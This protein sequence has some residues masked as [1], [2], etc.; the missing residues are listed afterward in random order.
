MW[1]PLGKA[2]ASTAFW[3]VSSSTSTRLKS[4][5][6][7]TTTTTDAAPQTPQD[8]F[9]A[10]RQLYVDLEQPGPRC[11]EPVPTLRFSYVTPPIDGMSTWRQSAAASSGVS[12]ANED[13]LTVATKDKPLAVYLPGLDGYGI[14]AA[15]NQFDDLASTFE[16]WRLT[17]APEDRSS[18]GTL[19]VSISDFVQELAQEDGRKVTLIGESCGGLLAAAVA[20]QLQKREQAGGRESSSLQGLVM[21]NPATSFDRTAWESLVPVLTSLQYLDTASP[22]DED[23]LTPYSVLGSLLLSSLIPDRDQQMRILDVIVNLPT[24]DIPPRNIEQ[25]ESIW[26]L[27]KQGFQETEF[28]LPPE[29]LEHRVTEWL[30]VGAPIINARLS[31]LELPTLVVAGQK[32]A[33]MPSEEEAKRLV[34]VIP[35]CQKLIVPNRGHFVLDDTVNLTEAILYSGVDPLEWKKTKKKYDPIVDWKLPD[36]AIVADTIDRTVKPFIQAHSPVFFSTDSKTGK[37]WRGL[38]KFPEKTGPLLIVGNHQLYGADLRI[39]F[40]A[41]M[42]EKNILPRGLAHPVLFMMDNATELQGRT[43]G[44]PWQSGNP[45]NGRDYLN[46]GAVPVSPRNFYRMLQTNQT[47]LLFPGGAKEALRAEPDYPLYWPDKLDFVRV[48]AKLNAT[49]VPLSAIGMTESVKVVLQPDDLLRVP[50]LGE[51]ARNVSNRLSNVRFDSSDDDPITP[52][53]VIPSLPARN[54]FIFGKARDMTD[55]D[56]NDRHACKRLYRQIESDV[57]VGLDDLIAARKKDPF[58]STPRRLAYERVFGKSAPSF[59]IDELN[60]PHW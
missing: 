37:R 31:E 43:A 56:P 24:L 6:G 28:R 38:S 52:S 49:V 14:S 11:R 4:P 23:R 46:F 36:A 30:T 12:S 5:L 10:F 34:Q 17:I 3:L 54:Y 26:E 39:I 57:R 1:W 48:A 44:L 50:F 2:L 58:V 59:T 29:L 33:L 51:Q 9:L 22:Q 8:L 7:A 15:R 13:D 18:F 19:V 42:D 47:A 41:L 35:S 53:L 45:L 16:F 27:T 40:S 20:L 60:K 55:V 32:D 25:L 21:V